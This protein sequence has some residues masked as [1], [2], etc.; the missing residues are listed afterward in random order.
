MTEP[1][2]AHDF[3]DVDNTS[4]TGCFVRYLDT[5]SGLDAV[6]DYKQLTFTMLGPR[7]GDQLL[8][9]GCGNG[10]DA[11]ELAAIV[12]STG[13]VLGVDKSAALIEEARERTRDAQLPVEFHVGDAHALAFDDDSFDGCRSDRT[14]QHLDD[15]LTALEEL[16]RITRPGGRVVI[17]DV[18]WETLVVDAS[19][20]LTRMV[21]NAL[22]D[23]CRQ[24]WIG[25]ELPRLFRKAGLL[26]IGAVPQTIIL[27]DFALAD[28][29]FSL[30][31]TAARLRQAGTASDDDVSAWIDE[32]TAAAEAHTFFSSLSGFIVRGRVP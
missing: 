17:S 11:Q 14:F 21:A 25:R 29:V 16:V 19:R 13:R 28:L 6:R 31:A 30:R 5:V 10:A 3:A 2:V 7:A 22:C 18:D 26:D 23:D 9:L 20:P 15:P 32:L 1:Y 4:E 27:T 24:G 8:D 12:G